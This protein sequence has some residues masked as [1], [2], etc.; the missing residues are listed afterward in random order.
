MKKSRSGS[1]IIARRAK[2]QANELLTILDFDCLGGRK[3]FR[4]PKRIIEASALSDLAPAM[5][6][7]ARASDEGF[8]V[9]GWFSYELGYLL[10]PKFRSLA[11][12]RSFPLLKVGVY[13]MPSTDSGIPAGEWWAGPLIPEWDFDR[14]RRAFD[15]IHSYICQGDIYQANLSFRA[16]FS[17]AGNGRAL[18]DHLRAHAQTPYCAYIDDGTRQIASLSPELFFAI[19]PDG[20]VNAKP[21]KGTIARS[22]NDA[23]ERLSLRSSEKDRAENLMIVDLIRNDLSRI[24]KVGT[25]RGTDLF[26]LESYP[27]FH[28][29]TSSITGRLGRDKKPGD[30]LKALFPCGS[31]TGAPKIRAMEILHSLEASPRNAYCGAIGM[32]SPDGSSVFNVGIR[33]I[34]LE[35]GVGE[36]GIGGAVVF[37]SDAEKE[38]AECVLKA[39]FLTRSIGRIDV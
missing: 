18:Y 15:T 14:Y 33:T 24:C 1:T 36:L 10:E 3:I 19:T 21:M 28:T 9:A 37:D 5:A 31:V 4:A 32:F 34:T 25:V 13:E 17:F 35:N 29:M 6:E 12:A 11:R 8:H 38:Y 30:I 20:R 39:Q 27:T 16:R 22:G 7:I 2:H 26:T 23:A